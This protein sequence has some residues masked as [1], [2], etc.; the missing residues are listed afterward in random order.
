MM[1]VLS[2]TIY[3]YFEGISEESK[4]NSIRVLDNFWHSCKTM[5]KS[6]A[7]VHVKNKSRKEVMQ[8]HL[9]ILNNTD[10]VIPSLTTHK[11][12]VKDKTPR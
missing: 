3:E 1:D 2:G 8:V 9:Y 12:I 4:A 6:S 5:Q 7:S 10:E 11:D